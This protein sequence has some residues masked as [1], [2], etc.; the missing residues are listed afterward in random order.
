MAIV[1]TAYINWSALW[2]IIA[3]ALIGGAGVVIVFG[4]LLLAVKH[5]QAAKTE[6]GKIAN[7]AL[8]GICGLLCVAA[9]V[10][11]IVA[12]ADK[13]SSHKSTSSKSKSAAVHTAPASEQRLVASVG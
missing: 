11:G 5:A 12:M 6:S 10:V 3:A 1:A 8:G 7:Y 4:F 9:V 2:K 13:P